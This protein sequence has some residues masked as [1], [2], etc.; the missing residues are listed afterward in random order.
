MHGTIQV[1]GVETQ[2]PDEW[3]VAFESA[4]PVQLDAEADRLR[5]R[6][7]A[8]RVQLT[9]SWARGEKAKLTPYGP[10]TRSTALSE[11]CQY[12]GCRGCGAARGGVS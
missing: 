12:L 11:M 2:K 3:S 9:V 1:R 5:E 8:P 10:A 4:D 6:Y 7:G